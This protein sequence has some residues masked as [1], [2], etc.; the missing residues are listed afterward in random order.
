MGS[1]RSDDLTAL[2]SNFL[3]A[4]FSNFHAPTRAHYDYRLEAFIQDGGLGRLQGAY[5]TDLVDEVDPDSHGVEVTEDDAAVLLEQLHLLGEP[6]YNV[7][8]FGNKPFDGLVEYFD[9]D[10]STR[11]P[12][13]GCAAVETRGLTLH[14]YR[15][16]RCQ[17]VLAGSRWPARAG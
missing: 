11:S 8:C 1:N 16:W 2:F 15:V 17:R 3:P 7:V 13:L 14:L 12:E 9:A 10:V 6:E 5:M 4:S